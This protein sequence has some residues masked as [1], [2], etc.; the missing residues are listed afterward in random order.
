MA[1]SIEYVPAAVIEELRGSHNLGV[2]IHLATDPPLHVWF[3]TADKVAGIDSIDPAG[4]VYLGGGRLIGLP[5]LEV[6]VNGTADSVEMTMSGIDP[7]T[8]AK[9]ID[10]IPEVRGRD[11]YLG[12]TTLDEYYQPMSSIIPLWN[13]AAS[14][15]IES[16]QTVTGATNRTQSLGLIVTSGEDTRSR[17]AYALWSPAHQRALSSTDAFCDGTARL[18][19][20]IYPAWPN[21]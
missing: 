6:L 10:S 4:T 13:G 12:M 17:P 1:Y 8:G 7:E 3:G 11:L 2:F 16:S 20:G 21:Y 18:A 5:T 14:H 15:I 9:M 19:R